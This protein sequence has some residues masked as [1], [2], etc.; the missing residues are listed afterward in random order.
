MQLD[1]FSPLQEVTT[2]ERQLHPNLSRPLHIAEF[3]FVVLSLSK[4]KQFS[5]YTVSTDTLEP[6]T[7]YQF[8]HHSS[9]IVFSTGLCFSSL[10]S[11]FV[12]C[13]GKRK[14]ELLLFYCRSSFFFRLAG[15]GPVV[16]AC[17]LPPRA[18]A[19]G[20]SSG[21]GGWEVG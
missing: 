17:L 3:C 9:V 19:A 2:N 18:A 7:S 10:F 1:L 15:G 13:V 14:K 6:R 20:Q 12:S 11:F 5:I 21:E 4:T 8:I 16:A